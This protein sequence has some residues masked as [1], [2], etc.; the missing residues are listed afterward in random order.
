MRND[1]RR[2]GDE[3]DAA[4]EYEQWRRSILALASAQDAQAGGPEREEAER[5]GGGHSTGKDA[6]AR[7]FVRPVIDHERT[8]GV[9]DAHADP[10]VEHVGAAREGETQVRAVDVVELRRGVLNA[11]GHGA[12]EV[13]DAAGVDVEASGE[14]ADI[15]Q[16][17]VEGHQLAR[18]EVH[19]GALVV[20]AAEHVV[21]EQHVAVAIA[22]EVQVER[23]ELG[24]RDVL[25]ARVDDGSVC[26]GG[27]SG[28]SRACSEGIGIPQRAVG[29][30]H[31]QLLHK[32]GGEGEREREEDS[33]DSAGSKQIEAV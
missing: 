15:V 31:I 16:A 30:R 28:S 26:S 7:V 12:E 23:V 2:A 10:T 1:A 13:A 18:G 32:G 33:T 5:T 9:V 17:I 4:R 25:R 22:V 27:G 11:V 6:G 21:L 3:S 14:R 24:D 8:G 19:R 20:A 29:G